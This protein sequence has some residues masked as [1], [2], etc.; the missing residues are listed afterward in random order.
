[1]GAGGGAA[2]AAAGDVC[3]GASYYNRIDNPGTN[4]CLLAYVHSYTAVVK[5]CSFCNDF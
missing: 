1:M 4:R 2:P 3:A 5:P